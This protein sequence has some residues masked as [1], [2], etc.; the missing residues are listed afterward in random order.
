MTAQEQWP[1]HHACSQND[2]CMGC[3][4]HRDLPYRVASWAWVLCSYSCLLTISSFSASVSLPAARERRERRAQGSRTLRDGNNDTGR[5]RRRPTTFGLAGIPVPDLFRLGPSSAPA[6][7]LAAALGEERDAHLDRVG[8]PGGRGLAR[9]ERPGVHT[10]MFRTVLAN[11]DRLASSLLTQLHARTP[12]A[13]GKQ[14]RSRAE[15]QQDT[16]EAKRGRQ[17]PPLRV[18]MEQMC[19]DVRSFCT[20]RLRLRHSFK[21]RLFIVSRAPFAAQIPFQLQ[22]SLLTPRNSVFAHLLLDFF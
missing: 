15:L 13:R 2:Q 21:R 8:C 3:I 19:R 5:A 11:V 16:G 14:A 7:G 12:S 18:L 22:T 1:R 10:R 20:G 9:R 4:T 17:S 6:F